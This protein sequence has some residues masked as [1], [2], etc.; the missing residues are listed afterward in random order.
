MFSQ[1]PRCQYRKNQ[2]GEVICQLRFPEI[3]SIE[4]EPPASF[5]E[6]IRQEF[7]IYSCRRDSILANPVNAGMRP[8][9]STLVRNHQF[10]SEDGIWRVNLTSTF[11]SL[12][13][14]RYSTWEEFAQRL[15]KPLAAF[16]QVYRPAFFERAGLRY[17]NFISKHALGLDSTPWRELIESRY[18]GILAEETVAEQSAF[19]STVDAEI[20]LVG[21]CRLKLHAGPGRIK[22]N[23]VQEDEIRFI[24]DQDLFHAGKLPVHMSAVVLESL[25]RQA[26]SVFR[27]A[28]TDTL[29]TY[30]EPEEI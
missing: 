20:A 10:M 22:R 28:I 18:L 5:Q 29:H 3:L 1:E 24:F 14:T 11:I 25:H 4:T 6:A 9:Q 16:I 8:Q 27:G 12:A 19:R 23:G 7:P 13:C 26:Y 15:D 21:G 2:L 17:L 30:M